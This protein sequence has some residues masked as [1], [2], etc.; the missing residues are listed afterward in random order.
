MT[1]RR[2][3]FGFVTAALLAAQSG[4]AWAINPTRPGRG[5]A[6]G[7]EHRSR[8]LRRSAHDEGAARR[9][10]ESKLGRGVFE[11]D[12]Q[13]ER[14]A[15]LWLAGL[16]VEGASADPARAEADARARLGELIGILAPD[17]KLRDFVLLGQDIDPSSGLRSVAFVQQLDGHPIYG[18][19]LSFRYAHDRLVG[20]AN[21]SVPVRSLRG[22][23][24]SLSRS[25]LVARA[26]AA[27]SV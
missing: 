27:L 5:A 25:K 16:P 20:I 13:S 8:S 24:A 15:R 17:A 10:L 14:P 21:D 1:G 23:G 11:F 3:F 12:D 4:E 19:Q 6:D 18:A 9:A 26:S 2:L 7:A 22:R